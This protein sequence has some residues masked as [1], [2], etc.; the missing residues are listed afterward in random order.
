MVVELSINKESA[1]TKGIDSE[2]KYLAMVCPSFAL[3]TNIV[4]SL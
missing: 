3:L 1:E 4:I 2:F